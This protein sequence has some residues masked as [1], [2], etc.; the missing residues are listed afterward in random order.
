MLSSLDCF[1]E[2]PTVKSEREND[3]YARHMLRLTLEGLNAIRMQLCSNDYRSGSSVTLFHRP[4]EATSLN[5]LTPTTS[6]KSSPRLPSPLATASIVSSIWRSRLSKFSSSFL[7]LSKFRSSLHPGN[8]DTPL[9]V[10]LGQL[11]AG[12]VDNI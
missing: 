10:V 4:I 6:M 3:A 8:T 11:H 2:H 1:I 9:G 5:S 12:F 7:A